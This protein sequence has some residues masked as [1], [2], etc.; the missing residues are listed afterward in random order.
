MD[1][2]EIFDPVP[3]ISPDPGWAELLE[4][5]DDWDFFMILS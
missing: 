5:D 2:D 4:K 1:T 3:Y